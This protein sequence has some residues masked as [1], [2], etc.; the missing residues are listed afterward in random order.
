M[1]IGFSCSAFDKT[2]TKLWDARNKGVSLVHFGFTKQAG[3]ADPISSD[4][5]R[6][7]DISMLKMTVRS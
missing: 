7:S 1:L 4:N 2:I 5:G 6:T 3:I